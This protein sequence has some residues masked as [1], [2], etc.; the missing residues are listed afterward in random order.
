M[1]DNTYIK[2]TRSLHTN[3]VYKS[4][5][6]EYRHIFMTILVNM[7]FKPV[8]M[9]DHGVLINLKPGQ[10][11]TTIRGLAKLC[12]EKGIDAPKVQRALMMYE[13]IGF[14]IQETIHKKTIITIKE[15]SICESLK[16]EVDTRIETKS[17]QDRYKIDTQKKNEKKEKNLKET[18]TPP[19]PQGGNRVVVSLA[20]LKENTSLEENDKMF[21]Q[22]AF[23]EERVKLA[24]EYSKHIKPKT[25][26]IQ[27]LVWHCNMENPPTVPGPRITEQQKLAI[28]FNK[29]LPTIGMNEIH[30]QNKS[31]ILDDI[32]MI[33][34]G[35][36]NLSNPLD[37]VRKR[38]ED[39]KKIYR[40]RNSA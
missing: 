33:P 5:S 13:N 17:I 12:D 8:Q 10:F 28:E 30:E 35:S 1:E 32:C 7:A 20:C 36:V 14:S 27:M 18:T 34:N 38:F 6:F 31:A 39:V 22:N 15:P 37:Y 24:L 11:M 40:Q 19:S 9:N 4:L 3:P 29:Y 2:Y 16:K 21:L 26:L 23:P 25:T